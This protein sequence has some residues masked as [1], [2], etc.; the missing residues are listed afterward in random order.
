MVV[1]PK[2]KTIDCLTSELAIQLLYSS[3]V[4][5]FMG[6]LYAFHG[7]AHLNAQS[8]SAN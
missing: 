5:L 7:G 8:N 1:D 3:E 4:F 2:G 6:G